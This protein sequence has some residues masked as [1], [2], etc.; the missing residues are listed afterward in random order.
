MPKC[1]CLGTGACVPSGACTSSCKV[2]LDTFKQ[3]GWLKYGHAVWCQ[4]C[5]FWAF[6]CWPVKILQIWMW[7]EEK[8][9][10]KCILRDTH[11][12]MD[13]Q[14]KNEIATSANVQSN[15]RQNVE[16]SVRWKQQRQNSSLH[17]SI[18]F[19]N[20]WRNILPPFL[21]TCSTV[22][23]QMHKLFTS[24]NQVPSFFEYSVALILSQ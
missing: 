21:P 13:W 9:T 15:K 5:Y 20:A 12:H 11:T 1:F 23:Y 7:M 14:C 18:H 24:V 4:I 16:S 2:L 6:L 22:G 10:H 3:M 19:P 17:Q 8:S